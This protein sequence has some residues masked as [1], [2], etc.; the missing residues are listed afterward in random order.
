MHTL[1][2]KCTI[3]PDQSLILMWKLR[4]LKYVIVTIHYAEDYWLQFYFESRERV[5]SSRSIPNTYVQVQSQLASE[6]PHKSH[7]EKTQYKHLISHHRHNTK[8]RELSIRSVRGQ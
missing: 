8:I 7:H 2:V 3:I 6:I 5:L 1:I 4:V